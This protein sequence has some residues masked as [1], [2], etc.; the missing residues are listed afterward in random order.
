MPS[1]IVASVRQGTDICLP[2]QAQGCQGVFLE[3]FRLEGFHP[4]MGC[5]WQSMAATKT[6]AR[7][8][9]AGV[10]SFRTFGDEVRRH[11]PSASLDSSQLHASIAATL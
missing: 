11:V 3:V 2:P 7:A 10:I 9:H 4:R 8:P 1:K 6:L 5:Q